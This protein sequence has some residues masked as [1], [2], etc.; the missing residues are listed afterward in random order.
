MYIKQRGY[1]NA[2]TPS[3]LVDYVLPKYWMSKVYSQRS[4]IL[5]PA[6]GSGI[7]SLKL[8]PYC[9]YML[10][11]VETSYFLNYKILE[12]NNRIEINEEAVRNCCLQLYLAL[13]IIKSLL[14]LKNKPLPNLIFGTDK[15]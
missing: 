3:T 7:F 9:T 15:K 4:S 6:C 5:D 8:S 12:I 14:Y 13:F 11:D 1:W 10:K 2:Y